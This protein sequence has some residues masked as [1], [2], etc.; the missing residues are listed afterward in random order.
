MALSGRQQMPPSHLHHPRLSHSTRPRDH[1]PNNAFSPPPFSEGGLGIPHSPSTPGP[2]LDSPQPSITAVQPGPK[3]CCETVCGH[4]SEAPLS[5]CSPPFSHILPLL[6]PPTLCCRPPP[7]SPSSSCSVL[8]SI[9]PSLS[10][11]TSSPPPLTISLC[12]ALALPLSSLAPQQCQ[13]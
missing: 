5:T 12:L 3:P 11:C 7:P 13:A 1:R 9:P 2:D 4:C 6:G 8:L 10:R